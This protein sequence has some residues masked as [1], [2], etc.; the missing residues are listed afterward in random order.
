[1]TALRRFWFTFK[2]PPLFSPLGL[3]CGIT[4]F[5][6]EDAVNILVSMVFSDE[7]LPEIDSVIEDVNIQTL[8]QKR[9]VPNIGLVVVRGVWFPLGYGTAPGDRGSGLDT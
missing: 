3:G 5:D 9:V 4:A 8:D 2:N 7:S 6:Y 1:M